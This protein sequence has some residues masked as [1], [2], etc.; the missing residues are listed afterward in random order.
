MNRLTI[1]SKS[2]SELTTV[3]LK[4]NSEQSVK[5]LGEDIVKV[6]FESKAAINFNLGDYITVWGKTYT[7]NT[8]PVVRKI[9]SRLFEY[10]VVFESKLYDLSKVVFLDLDA[11]GVHMSHEFFV[12]G[13]I[14]LFAS[15]IENNLQRVYGNWTV[16]TIGLDGEDVKNLSFSESNCQQ[17]LKQICDEFGCEFEII[18]VSGQNELVLREMTGGSSGYSFEYGKGNGLYDIR[19]SL[20][21][22]NN[23]TTRLYAFGSSKNIGANYRDYSPRLRLP[24]INETPS[25]SVAIEEITEVFPETRVTGTTNAWNVKL[26]IWT[27]I[28]FVDYG[29]TMPGSVFNVHY[30]SYSQP[31]KVDFFRIKA[32]N[33]LGKYVYS[34]GTSEGWAVNW[35]YIESSN[36]SSLGLFERVIIFDDIFPEREGTV[37]GLGASVYQFADS[38]MFDLNELDSNGD[39][40]YLIQDLDAKISFRTGNLA[41][42]EFL[43]GN[44]DNA[45]KTFTINR[46][47]DE[48]G[49]QFP[50]ETEPAFQI[51]P[52]DKFVI[53][54]ITM[55]QSYIED[56][57][58]RLSAKATE[59]LNKYS[60]EQVVYELTIDPIFARDN[61]ITFGV[62]DAV[63]VT[64]S[65]LGV[66][67][68]IRITE[69]VRN[70]VNEFD[71]KVKL[72]DSTYSPKKKG[73]KRDEL[74]SRYDNQLK[75]SGI[76]ADWN[77]TNPNEP[78]FIK[79]KP[80]LTLIADKNIVIP[81][82]YKLFEIISHGLGKEPAV[83]IVGDDNLESLAD[84]EHIDEN[85]VK[86]TFSNYFT[87]R[88]VFN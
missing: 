23:L 43:I 6:F 42:Y 9:A 17:A 20:S 8:F 3:A 72:S 45:S 19:R 54:D 87:G 24:M 39:P 11:S 63:G 78:T 37:T 64:D 10:E 12:T 58:Y 7:L 47:T 46:Y 71:F 59:W 69:V 49:T 22:S 55:P 67:E 81:I 73:I 28:M 15:L 34:D 88:I 33:Q 82:N 16:S 5:L 66:S 85:T 25:I 36:L 35:D 65:D 70:L 21:T 32:W 86:I 68:Q 84:I 61:S 27:G 75:L 1:Y 52:G 53:L 30:L 62:G 79:N 50:S 14:D 29:Q 83:T 48:R 76:Q 44:F 60:N 38:G 4:T 41:G 74:K 57:E 18:S 26:Q 56:A 2:G 77:E 31:P 51:Q 40:K 13:N 80:D